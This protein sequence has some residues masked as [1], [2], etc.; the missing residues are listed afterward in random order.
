MSQSNN[1]IQ[2]DPDKNL[3]RFYENFYRTDEFLEQF[4]LQTSIWIPSVKFHWILLLEPDGNLLKD[5][6]HSLV[7]S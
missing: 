4:K 3:I 5:D 7:M 6:E 2:S 1:R